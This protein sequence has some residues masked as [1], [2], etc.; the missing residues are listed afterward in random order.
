MKSASTTE[1]YTLHYK[2]RVGSIWF[3]YLIIWSN[4]CLLCFLSFVFSS[5]H[6]FSPGIGPA[7]SALQSYVTY[8]GT[9][10]LC[11]FSQKWEDG[12]IVKSFGSWFQAETDSHNEGKYRL[13]YI[14]LLVRAMSLLKL[15]GIAG[16][17]HLESLKLCET[18]S[19]LYVAEPMI[20]IRLPVTY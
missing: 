6:G 14:S 10:V 11:L 17:I 12:F 1:S 8:P 15:Y 13:H 20:P 7:F 16:S 3:C 18:L 5:S 4:K 19:V 9:S 2:D